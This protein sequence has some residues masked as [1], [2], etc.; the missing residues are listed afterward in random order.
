MSKLLVA[1][2]FGSTLLLAASA[3]AS[4]DS[5]ARAAFNAALDK[6]EE[7][8]GDQRNDCTNEAMEAY[9]EAREKEQ[10]SK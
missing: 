4:T 10:M 6:C 8:T 7:M 5:A 2:L 1:A 9:R 3:Q